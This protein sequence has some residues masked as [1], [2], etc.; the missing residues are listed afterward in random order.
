LSTTQTVIMSNKLYRGIR[1]G[2]V[3]KVFVDNEELSL[4]PSKI[5]HPSE[6]TFEFGYFGDGPSQTALAILFDATQDKENALKY[7]HEFKA[8]FIAPAD[9]QVGFTIFQA[10]IKE[11]LD[12]KIAN[13][14]RGWII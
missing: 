14:S 5:L 9:Y 13:D 8:E 10:T 1:Q 11:W 2:I 12:K 7:Y 6:A 3:A 4:E